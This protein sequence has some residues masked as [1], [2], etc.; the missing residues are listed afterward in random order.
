MHFVTVNYPAG[1]TLPA[2]TWA[3]NRIYKFLLRDTRANEL[4]TPPQNPQPGQEGKAKSAGSSVKCRLCTEKTHFKGH[5]YV[6][7]TQY[8]QNCFI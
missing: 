6:V 3:A 1:L 4:I 5:V 8:C 2:V 7:I